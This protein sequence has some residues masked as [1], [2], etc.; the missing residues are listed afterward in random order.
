MA[1]NVPYRLGLIGHPVSHSKSPEIFQGFFTQMGHT[2]ANYQLFNLPSLQQFEPWIQEQTNDSNPLVGFNVTVPYKTAII[3]HL[4]QLTEAAKQLNAVNTV[5]VHRN[6]E[7]NA[8]ELHGHNTDVIGFQFTLNQLIKTTGISPHE[9][10]ILGNGGSAKAVAFVL[11]SLL[12]PYR[13][14]H[15]NHWLNGNGELVV[16]NQ[17]LIVQTTPVGMWPNTE[18]C[19]EFP[20]HLLNETNLVI[21]LIYNPENTGF[22]AKATKQGAT[23]INGNSM[24]QQQANS[25]WELFQMAIPK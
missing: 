4:N 2:E 25:A 18:E 22:M 14:W 13:T 20:F 23:A 6:R 21:D 12:I 24:L 16:Q 17:T 11:E 19:L 15:R 1:S 3:P 7:T 8:A 10:I 9:A 5:V